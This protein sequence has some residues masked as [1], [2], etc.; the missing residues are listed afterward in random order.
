[1]DTTTTERVVSAAYIDQASAS[2]KRT[3][4]WLVTVKQGS[5]VQTHRF[6]DEDKAKAFA[7]GGAR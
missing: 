5:T 1:M 3:P 6:H 2:R 4:D 7:A